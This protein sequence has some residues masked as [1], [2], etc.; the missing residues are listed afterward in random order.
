MCQALKYSKEEKKYPRCGSCVASQ[1]HDGENLKK[2]KKNIIELSPFLFSS[3]ST[4]MT[5]SSIGFASITFNVTCGY[6]LSS[7]SCTDAVCF[8]VHWVCWLGGGSSLLTILES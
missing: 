4:T 5:I 2:K 7:V 1:V 6:G 3:A 8:L